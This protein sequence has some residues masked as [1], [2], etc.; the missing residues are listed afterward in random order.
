MKIVTNDAVYVQKNDIGYLNQTD[1][2]IP[3][4]IYIKIFGNGVVIIDNSNRFEFVKFEEDSEIE[5]FK[6]LDWIVD[7]NVLKDMSVEKIIELGQSVAQE[8]NAIAKTYNAM[9]QNDRMKNNHMVSECDRLD[10]KMYSL[11]DVIL[12]KQGLINFALPD[13]LSTLDDD[14]KIKKTGLRRLLGK[15]GR[16]NKI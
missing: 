1:L 14:Q 6:N 2:P 4:S 7:Y 15:F 16:K 9:N 5:Y 11:R 10:F 13:C 3:A 12:F 8:K